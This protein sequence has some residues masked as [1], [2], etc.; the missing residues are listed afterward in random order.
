MPGLRAKVYDIFTNEI[1]GNDL[2]YKYN[3]DKQVHRLDFG[4]I[5]GLGYRLMRG[6]G[7]IISAQY[8]YGIVD[9]T[10]DDATPGQFTTSLYITAAIPIGAG[11]A[12]EKNASK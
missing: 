6:K 5:A 2:E 8:Y 10:I 7:M 1:D 9:V 11:K 3:I 4:F 12:K